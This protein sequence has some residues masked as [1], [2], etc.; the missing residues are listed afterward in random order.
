MMWFH[1]KGE[2][3]YDV[4]THDAL[5]QCSTY[6]EF[7]SAVAHEAW[8]L[9]GRGGHWYTRMTREFLDGRFVPIFPV[10]V[11]DE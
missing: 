5:I 11:N 7:E 3:L 6:P 8:T 2:E 9:Y 4:L 10:E 1:K